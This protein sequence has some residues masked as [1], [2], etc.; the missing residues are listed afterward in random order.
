VKTSE[1]FTLND[2]EIITHPDAKN[3]KIL[4]LCHPNN[5]T[6]NTIP[7]KKIRNILENF[8]GMVVVDEAY[9]DF[10][11]EESTLK[12]LK[13]YPKLIVLQTFS[14][15]WGLAGL[16]LGIVF[17]HSET[18][19]FIKSVKAPYNVNVLTAKETIKALDNKEEKYQQRNALISERF[20]LETELEKCEI[21]HKIYPSKCNSVLI[22]FIKNISANDVYHALKLENIIVRNFS[23]KQYL[24]N[25]IRVSVGLPK[26]NKKVIKV[27]NTLRSLQELEKLKQSIL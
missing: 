7:E 19:N 9:I 13:K 17:A 22:K 5:P 8:S 23:H 1:D 4:F 12:F 6:G 10:I 18:I 26:E 21:V 16:R 24:E 25:C 15:M 11:S 2:Q 14:K 20:Y 27:I 3:S